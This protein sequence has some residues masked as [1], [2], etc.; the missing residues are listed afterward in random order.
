VVGGVVGV[1]EEL[2]VPVGETD[3]GGVVEALPA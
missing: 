2:I 3:V 1:G